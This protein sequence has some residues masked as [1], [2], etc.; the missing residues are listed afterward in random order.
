LLC[1]IL[2]NYCFS[3][4]QLENKALAFTQLSKGYGRFILKLSSMEQAA[5]SNQVKLKAPPAK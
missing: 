1:S 2:L 3:F 5:H 4:A